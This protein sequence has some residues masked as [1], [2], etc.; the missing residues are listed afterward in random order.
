MY[1]GNTRQPF[2]LIIMGETVYVIT[3]AHDT[4][5]IFR[6][7][8]FSMDPWLKDLT[9]QF[10]ASQKS[11][12]A[13]WRTIPTSSDKCESGRPIDP[14]IGLRGWEDKILKDVCVML[15]RLFLNPGQLSDDIL[16]VLLDTV[17]TR[18]SWNAV[19]AFTRLSG[20]DT[21]CTVSLLKWSQ[22]VLLEGATN[23]FFGTSL[24]ELEPSLFESFFEFDDS[25]W[26]LPYRIPNLFAKDVQSSKATAERALAQYFDLPREKRADAALVTHEI[27]SAM[28]ASGISSKDMGVLVL[29]FYWV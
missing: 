4:G 5:V 17:H 26:K 14:N 2:E 16:H 15:F 8:A 1:F 9:H 7:D 11:I 23:S 6:S 10:G 22:H 25:S 24:L 28:R 20:S 13:M 19:P 12:Q 27:E 21:E 3:S 29:M 18:M